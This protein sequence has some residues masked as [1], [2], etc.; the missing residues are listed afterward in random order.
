M[1]MS[2]R[3]SVGEFFRQS[4]AIVLSFLAFAPVFLVGLS[5]VPTVEGALPT[6]REYYLY[7]PSS[8]AYI[9][10]T[11]GVE[12]MFSVTGECAKYTFDARAQAERFIQSLQKEWGAKVRFVEEVCGITSYYCYSPR[13]FGGVCLQGQ[14]VNLHIAVKAD[15]RSVAVASPIIFGGY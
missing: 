2:K 11:Y 3:R 1:A 7:S 10:Q 5:R 14:A 4:G 9:A 15:G 13:L 12:E 8:Q 6:A